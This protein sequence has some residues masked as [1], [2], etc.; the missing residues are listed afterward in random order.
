MA[1]NLDTG[2]PRTATTDQTGR[3]RLFT[4]P[5]GLYEIRVTK[6][7]ILDLSIVREFIRKEKR[8]SPD[9]VLDNETVVDTKIDVHH[10]R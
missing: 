9:V 2:V 1:I 6:D 8:D 7:G 10:T 5:L 3:Y 4:L